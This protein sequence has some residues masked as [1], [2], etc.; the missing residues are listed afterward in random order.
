PGAADAEDQAHLQVI[1]QVLPDTA[2]IEHHRDAVALQVS[3]RPDA[4]QHENVRR[5][6][7]ARRQDDLA[8]AA[9]A[10]HHAVLAPAQ[11]DRAAAVELHRLDQATELQPE[12]RPTQDGL[13]EAA[14]GRPAP[15][16]LLA[17]VILRRALVVAGIELVDRGDSSLGGR[18]A[19][20]V[21]NGKLH[22]LPL[23]PALAAGRVH[24]ARP[25]AMILVPLE[26]RQ[27]VI[28]APAGKAKLA[29]EIVVAGLA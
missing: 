23:D 29:P 14:R 13:E 26:E 11:A 6:N 5:S 9:G 17:H 24:G 25:Q 3:R 10:A 7:G 27:H 19:E 21:E 18:L 28:P 1:L 16:A 4:R 8:A 12:V 15:A 20:G 2:R 22:A